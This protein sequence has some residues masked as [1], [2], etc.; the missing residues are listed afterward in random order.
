MTN[1]HDKLNEIWNCT[2][3]YTGKSTFSEELEYK[4]YGE[5]LEYFEQYAHIYTG[6]AFEKDSKGRMHI[7][8][9]ASVPKTVNRKT[10][11][12]NYK[13]L[14]NTKWHVHLR[15]P[16][17][18]CDFWEAY[19]SKMIPKGKELREKLKNDVIK[20]NKI[21]NKIY[22]NDDDFIYDPLDDPFEAK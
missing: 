2:V 20:N 11:I 9:R 7:H 10:T 15:K 17:K 19:M 18:C 5:Y 1:K 13:N 14:T 12:C 6:V 4:I 3:K 22:K 16:D 21:I 8:F